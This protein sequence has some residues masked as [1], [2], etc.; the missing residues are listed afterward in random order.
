MGDIKLEFP[1]IGVKVLKS[2]DGFGEIEVFRGASY[3]EAVRRA[4]SGREVMVTSESIGVCKWAPV[5]LGLKPPENRFEKGIGPRMEE[6]F[7]GYYLAPMPLFRKGYNADVVIVRGRPEQLEAVTD[8]IGEESLA[9]RYTGEVGKTALGV[10]KSGRSMML[11]LSRGLFRLLAT[12]RRSKSWDRFTRFAFRSRRVSSAFERIIRNTMGD[13]S[14]CRNS[15]VIPY[16]ENAANVSFF[17]TGAV[18]W[19]A[20]KPSHL[21]SGLPKEMFDRVCGRLEFPGYRRE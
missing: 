2:L 9:G 17:C 20:N 19:G 10:D 16:L 14:M 1:P 13:M 5:I 11:R 6:P 4:T 18:A 15:T 8:M 21:T 12:L 3:C 7:S